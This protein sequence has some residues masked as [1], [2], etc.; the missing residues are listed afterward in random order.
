M[1][2]YKPRYTSITRIER[3]APGIKL[4]RLAYKSKHKP[5]QFVEVFLPHY[6]EAPMSICSYSREYIELC[7][8]C[9]GNL[10]RALHA[11]HIDDKIGVRGPYGAGY[12]VEEFKGKHLYLIGGGT[13]VAPLR[14][15]I[16]YAERHPKD[17]PSIN[18]FLGFRTPRDVLFKGDIERW[19]TK[20][21][22]F[23]SVDRPTKS[24]RHSR[25]VITTLLEKQTLINKNSVAMVCGPPIMIKFV[26]KTLNQAGFDDEQIYVSME[27]LMRCGIGKCGHCM[28]N[29][30]YV[31]KDGPVFRYDT[32]KGR[33]E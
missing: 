7:V 3:L 18:I 32:I 30:L 2:P 10:T 33:S 19:Q 22:V 8:R 17:F 28:I 12:P 13:G 24:W 9:V 11:L 15:V 25:G 21:R 31:C 27:R 5:G 4:Y 1:N 26:I 29:E 6:G 16:L 14:S 20:F 23:L